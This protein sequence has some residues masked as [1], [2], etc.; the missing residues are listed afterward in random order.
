[1]LTLFH[2]HNIK[3][4]VYPGSISDGIIGLIWYA[5]TDIDRAGRKSPFRIICDKNDKQLHS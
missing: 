1:M 5:V 2:M 4:K 3:F